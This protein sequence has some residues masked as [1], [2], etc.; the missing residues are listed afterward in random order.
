MMVFCAGFDGLVEEVLFIMKL[1]DEDSRNF[2]L[3][4]FC[5]FISGSGMRNLISCSLVQ[6][7]LSAILTGAWLF[8]KWCHPCF[9][10]ANA[11]ANAIVICWLSTLGI[12]MKY[13]VP[14]PIFRTIHSY[15]GVWE[16]GS[17]RAC[18]LL[19]FQRRVKGWDDCCF[20]SATIKR[21]SNQN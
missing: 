1:C 4:G 7:G 13:V 21:N 16:D 2:S 19:F 17:P 11:F 3:V 14:F 10:I 12:C 6:C 9:L 5:S 8:V 18:F 20:L 15:C